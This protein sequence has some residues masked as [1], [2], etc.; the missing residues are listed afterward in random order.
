MYLL[1]LDSEQAAIVRHSLAAA[2]GFM[3]ARLERADPEG[4]ISS[5]L[6]LQDL[7]VDHI[8]RQLTLSYVER[9]SQIADALGDEIEKLMQTA[10]HVESAADRRRV[11]TRLSNLMISAYRLELPERHANEDRPSPDPAG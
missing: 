9:Q 6:K 5:S 1:V 11:A 7:K 4:I 3:T 8:E 2:R 10:K